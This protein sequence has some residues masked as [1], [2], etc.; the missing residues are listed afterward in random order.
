M[1]PYRSSFSI[2]KDPLCVSGWSIRSYVIDNTIQIFGRLFILRLCE[3]QEEMKQTELKNVVTCLMS[4]IT[5]MPCGI[6]MISP[7]AFLQH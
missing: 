1:P 4:Q 6:I 7:Y 2:S 5:R 3:Q